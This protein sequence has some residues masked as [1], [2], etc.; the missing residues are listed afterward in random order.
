MPISL[1]GFFLNSSANGNRCVATDLGDE[2][3]HSMVDKA[4]YAISVLHKKLYYWGPTLKS[5][6]VTAW[7]WQRLVS[8]GQQHGKSM[9]LGAFVAVL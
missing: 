9:R 6:M 5:A 3:M 8:E 2:L 4:L 7:D 1:Q